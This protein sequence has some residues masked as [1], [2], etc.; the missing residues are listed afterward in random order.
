MKIFKII[1]LVFLIPG[2]VFAASK[3][4]E[5]VVLY[6][7]GASDDVAE[8]EIGDDEI[9]FEFTKSLFDPK[10]VSRKMIPGLND[11]KIRRKMKLYVNASLALGGSFTT[12][13]GVEKATVDTPEYMFSYNKPVPS[14]TRNY[15][16]FVLGLDAGILAGF[17]R[18]A[19]VGGGLNFGYGIPDSQFI[20][21]DI[22]DEAA[23]SITA[24]M[25]QFNLVNYNMYVLP[26]LNFMFGDLDKLKAA[27]T[28]D[29][30]GGYG[31]LGSLGVYIMG[32]TAKAGFVY[33]GSMLF[34]G[35]QGGNFY[36]SVGYSFNWTL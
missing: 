15:S 7:T 4:D 28:F 11:K 26:S 22:Y 30:G 27:V 6:L 17:S 3:D 8:D 24:D 19:A 12:F 36:F 23:G 21:A 9:E 35:I 2:F 16:S 25:E 20:I 33:P 29:V 14:E 10:T 13:S 34:N 5:E 18:Y 31:I 32:V 1:M